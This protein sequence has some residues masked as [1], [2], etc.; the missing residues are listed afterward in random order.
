MLKMC[1]MFISTRS[2]RSAVSVAE[3]RFVFIN[4]IFQPL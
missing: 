4:A 3:Q 1:F 2:A